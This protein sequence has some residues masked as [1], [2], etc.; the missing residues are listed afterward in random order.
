MN[1]FSLKEKYIWLSTQSFEE[2]SLKPLQMFSLKKNRYSIQL[3]IGLNSWLDVW[4][5]G[6]EAS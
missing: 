1:L 3:I 4:P 2:H 5:E 6:S